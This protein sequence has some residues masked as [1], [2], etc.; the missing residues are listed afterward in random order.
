LWKRYVPHLIIEVFLEKM[1]VCMSLNV[2]DSAGQLRMARSV[3]RPGV[4]Q[5]PEVIEKD[6]DFVECAIERVLNAN[7][8]ILSA[9]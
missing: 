1:R 5:P 3:R 6:G 7:P 8:E 9:S 2:C 4:G